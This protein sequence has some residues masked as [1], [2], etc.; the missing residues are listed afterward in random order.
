M[1]YAFMVIYLDD[2]VVYNQTLVQ[3]EKHLRMVFQ[4]LR[5][6]RLYVK[7]EKCGFAQ[8][9]ILV[10]KINTDL[11]RMDEGKVQAIKEWPVPSKLTKLRSFLDLTNYYRRFIKGYSKMV[12]PLIDPSKKDNKWDWSMQCQMAFESLKEA[13]S[14]KLVLRL[15]DLDFPFEVQTNA[16]DRAL[17]GVL[18]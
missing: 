3:H 1:R 11:I 9:E 12:F 18:V 15:P 5:E 8:E 17:G 4:R 7:L 16:S 2:I 14:T 13:I 6:H 10:H